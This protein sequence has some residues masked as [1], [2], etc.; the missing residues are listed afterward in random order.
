MIHVNNH[1]VYESE[2]IIRDKY[3][4][5]PNNGK[6]VYLDFFSSD[7]YRNIYQATMD[8]THKGNAVYRNSY[9]MTILIDGLPRVQIKLKRPGAGIK[10]AIN[11]VVRSLQLIVSIASGQL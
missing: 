2:K 9:D 6:T 5:T 11:R 4:P 8:K 7:I 1:S 3:V 10:E